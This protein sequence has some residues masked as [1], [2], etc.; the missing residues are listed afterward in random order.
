MPF[1]RPVNNVQQAAMADPELL[2]TVLAANTQLLKV[3]GLVRK[4]PIDCVGGSTT[5]DV[6]IAINDNARTGDRF[7][8]WTNFAPAEARSTPP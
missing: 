6:P 2:A 8:F 4:Y 5:C 1:Y 3:G 7:G